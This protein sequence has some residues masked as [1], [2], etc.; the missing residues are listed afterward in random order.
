MLVPW[1]VDSTRCERNRLIFRTSRRYTGSGST[2]SGV[3]GSGET[4]KPFLTLPS[5]CTGPLRSSISVDSYENP[6]NFVGLSEPTRN[7]DGEPVRM[8]GCSKLTFPAAITVAPDVKNASSSSGLT[9]GVHVPQTA[10]FNPDGLGES[11]LRDTTVA[12]PAG[13]TIN[14]AGAGGLQA[15]SE[16]LAGFTGFNGTQP[17]IRRGCEV[18]DILTGTDRIVAAGRELLSRWG[19]DRDGASQDPVVGQPADGCCV[20]GVSERKPVREPDRDVHDGRRPRVW[21]APSSSRVKCA[22]AKA[23]DRS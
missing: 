16:G 17:G 20:S 3:V 21:A 12:L 4:R 13:V 15:C 7:A 11:S 14:P 18:G 19:E 2:M 6:G 1:R 10:A 22:C 8:T 5:S 23:R 9:V